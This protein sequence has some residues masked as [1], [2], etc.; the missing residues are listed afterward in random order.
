MEGQG[1]RRAATVDPPACVPFFCAAE[2]D[3]MASNPQFDFHVTAASVW[4]D[5]FSVCIGV[6]GV[7]LVLFYSILF[8][9]LASLIVIICEPKVRTDAELFLEGTSFFFFDWS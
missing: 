3:T 2:R 5:S 6:S 7:L 9:S 4:R 8:C 1:P